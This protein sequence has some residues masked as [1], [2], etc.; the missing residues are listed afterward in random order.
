MKVTNNYERKS[1]QKIEIG[2]KNC[3]NIKKKMVKT[4]FFSI[5]NLKK[6]IF[7]N[8]IEFL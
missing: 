8:L 3:A 4:N 7:F 1:F 6:E 2:K 5:Y